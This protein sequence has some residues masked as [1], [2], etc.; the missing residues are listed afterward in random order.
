MNEVL[1][2]TKV[3]DKKLIT[4]DLKSTTKKGAIEELSELLE[5]ENYLTNKQQFIDD[6]LLREEEGVTGIGNGIAIPHGKSE[7]VQQTTIVIG[8]TDHLIEWGSLD[9]EPINVIIM[10]AVK[11]TDA[12]TTHIKLLQ[13]VAIMLA[14]D[15]F[16]ESLRK[17]QTKEEL[18]ELIL[19]KNGGK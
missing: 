9:D 14:D 1:D 3:L 11:K 17:A 8:K 2:I 5:T 10:F 13:K 16:L 12:T 19:K 15:Q 18:F 7:G 4:T 6:V